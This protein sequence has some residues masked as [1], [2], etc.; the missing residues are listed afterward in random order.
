MQDQLLSLDCVDFNPKFCHIDT[1]SDVA[2][3]AVDLEMFLAH[4][5]G[6]SK[7]QP[8]SEKL[9]QHFLY[10]YLRAANESEAV[11]PVL[12]FY[13]TEKAMICAYMCILS[14][15][16]PSLG[17]QYLDVVLTRSKKLQ[18]YLPTQNELRRARYLTLTLGETIRH[19]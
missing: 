7:P 8:D 16:Q 12:E 10:T 3:I 6:S 9:V 15:K 18:Y 2:M 1:L 5:S 14:G 19:S 4:Q 11:W 13:M 17:E